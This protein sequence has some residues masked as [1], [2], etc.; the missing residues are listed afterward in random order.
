MALGYED[1]N[2]HA[3]LRRDPLGLDR[4]NPAFRGAALA[5]PCTLNRLEL[6]NNKSTRCHKLAHNPA[7]L[8]DCLLTMGARYLPR[9]AR[10]CGLP[11]RRNRRMILRVR[12]K[13]FIAMP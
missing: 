13:P 2:D 1:L 7:A 12:R 10:G 6:S 11:R 9:H 5:A 8:E 3:F 4:F